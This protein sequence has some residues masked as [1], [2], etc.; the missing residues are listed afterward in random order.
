MSAGLMITDRAPGNNDL[1][2]YQVGP[3]YTNLSHE[4]LR[5]LDLRIQELLDVTPLQFY[6]E[7]C[8]E[9]QRRSFREKYKISEQGNCSPSM[10]IW[11]TTRLVGLTALGG[12]IGSEFAGLASR[13]YGFFSI[14][15]M[16]R[17]I[18][19]GTL[20]GGACAA[21]Y[22]KSRHSYAAEKH[23]TD[24]VALSTRFL[25]WRRGLTKQRYDLYVAC[26]TRLL[27]T[28][29]VLNLLQISSLPREPVI[30]SDG[31]VCEKEEIK[32]YSDGVWGEIDNPSSIEEGLLTTGYSCGEAL[33]STQELQLAH[34]F[35]RTTLWKLVHLKEL[36]DN[37]E[38]VV[39]P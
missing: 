10:A 20:L 24:N 11:W 3:L 35:V 21:Y 27:G 32:A 16:V 4:E 6:E 9:E 36:Y 19:G 25:E 29:C 1:S 28:E 5:D 12:I 37:E 23:L 15:S 39:S 18:L 33:S 34:S 2:M 17:G 14:G 38:T 8:T 7:I 13:F 31:S 30:S 22:I 26:M